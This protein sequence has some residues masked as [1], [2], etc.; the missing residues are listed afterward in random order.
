[1][2]K[3]IWFKLLYIVTAVIVVINT[4]INV[5]NALFCDIE[6]LPSGSLQYSIQ[7]PY[8]D[9]KVNIYLVEN[10]VGQAI[11]GELQTA[12]DTKNIFWQ[13]DIE[14]VDVYWANE[15]SIIINNIPLNIEKGDDYDC[16]RG[17][18]IFADGATYERILSG[19]A[20]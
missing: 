3:S 20:F 4:A 19:E 18:S 7:S 17:T 16:R 11:R 8:G 1:M 10:S 2:K 14:N 6:E 9:G 13:T 5:K 15:E 12:T